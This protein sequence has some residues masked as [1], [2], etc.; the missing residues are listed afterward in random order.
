MPKQ[1]LVYSGG[2]PY[3]TLPAA[4]A[5]IQSNF[6]ELYQSRLGIL[7]ASSTAPARVKAAADYTCNG[8]ADDIEIQA[9]IGAAHAADLDVFC[10]G[11]QFNLANEVNNT[12]TEVTLFGQGGIQTER[13]KFV[14]SATARSC[15]FANAQ[16]VGA[17]GIVFDA[18]NLGNYAVYSVGGSRDLWRG[19]LF[20]KG[21]FDGF[22]QP[23]VP[24]T[25]NNGTRFEACWFQQNGRIFASATINV[26]P[27]PGAVTRHGGTVSITTGSA[28]VTG[29]STLFTQ[30]PARAGDLIK[31]G[32]YYYEID[33]VGG[34][35]GA[36][37]TPA[38]TS[39]TVLSITPNARETLTGAEYAI[40]IGDGYYSARYG[41]NNAAAFIDCQARSNAGC[42]L[43]GNGPYGNTVERG[44]YDTHFCMGVRFGSSAT[45]D[46]IYGGAVDRSYFEGNVG[47]AIYTA[48]MRGLAITEPMINQTGVA[49]TDVIAAVYNQV[50]SN[51]SMI[52]QGSFYGSS[53]SYQFSN[54]RLAED[55]NGKIRK[56]P[57]ASPASTAGVA[58]GLQIS[59]E[60][61]RTLGATALAAGT[62]T[63]VT[64]TLPV[65]FATLLTTAQKNALTVQVTPESLS[66]PSA[67]NLQ[68]KD[69]TTAGAFSFVA[70]VRNNHSAAQD[71]YV[72]WSVS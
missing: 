17:Q 46:V 39:D 37:G 63:T 58:N 64:I 33:E 72:N 57:R 56:V 43:N 20:K 6:D 35:V 65:A 44:F 66:G 12:G 47:G 24:T 29:V 5:K 50:S 40:C 11:G 69:T 18:N 45:G 54:W 19:C 7:V 16:A 25:V 3:D 53:A 28:T 61:G 41:D 13:T 36:G 22:H 59:P 30:V 8:T 67:A 27:F 26:A 31:I 10:S 60:V 71:V 2:G 23:R 38:I 51:W 1:T 55:G 48:F 49:D 42:G 14:L 15:F 32:A 9:A 21:L 70:R 62:E 52:Y 4:S 34:P 68:S